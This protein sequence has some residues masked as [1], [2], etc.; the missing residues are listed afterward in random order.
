VRTAGLALAALVVVQWTVG[1]LMV[2]KAL[3][4][5]LATAHNGIAALLVLA[6][7]A[8]LRHLWIPAARR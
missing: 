3:P 7:V 6:I 2:M 4:L 8:L 1:P 5:E